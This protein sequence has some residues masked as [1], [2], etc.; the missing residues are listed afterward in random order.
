MNKKILMFGIP[1]VLSIILVSAV[2]VYF[3]SVE[4]TITVNEAR[5]SID[6][7]FALT[8]NSGETVI[9]DLTIHNSANVPLRVELTFSETS[10]TGVTYT[11]NLP[12]VID[13]TANADTI[14]TVSFTC[15]PT[16]ESGT[17]VG[18]INYNKIA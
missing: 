14:T 13:L 15:N 17:L 10:N 6:L 11:N 5:S 2:V 16:T 18:L 1:I 4:A 8:C 12:S 9:K 3:H 7:P